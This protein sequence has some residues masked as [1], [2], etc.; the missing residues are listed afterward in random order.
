[1]YNVIDAFLSS[2]L[3]VF[4]QTNF[5]FFKFSCDNQPQIFVMF[6]LYWYSNLIEHKKSHRHIPA[7]LGLMYIDCGVHMDI[8]M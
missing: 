6:P 2:Y 1:M 5:C 8:V 3:C 7:L 4:I